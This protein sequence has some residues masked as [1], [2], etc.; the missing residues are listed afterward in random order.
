MLKDAGFPKNLWAEMT[1]TFCYVDNM[2]PSEWF[3]DDVPAELWLGKRQDVSH[4]RPVGCDI[5]AKLPERHCDRKLARQVIKGKMLGYVGQWGYQ[6]WVPAVR[7]VIESRD[8]CFEEGLPHRTL[9]VRGRAEMK[10]LVTE[11]TPIQSFHILLLTLVP[12]PDQTPQT[13]R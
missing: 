12:R 6:I 4:L 3:P 11:T 5:W 2:V 13:Y 10:S 8:V 7:K 1:S 9:P